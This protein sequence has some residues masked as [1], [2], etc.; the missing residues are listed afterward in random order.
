VNPQ[1][2]AEVHGLTVEEAQVILAIRSQSVATT[3]PESRVSR[4]RLALMSAQKRVGV[5]PVEVDGSDLKKGY[6]P[7]ADVGKAEFYRKQCGVTFDPPVR[8]SEGWE[9]PP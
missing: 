7:D 2:F 4:A 6:D 5:H 9:D 8:T 3:E 1:E